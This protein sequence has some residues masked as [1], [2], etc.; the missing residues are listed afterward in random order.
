MHK[1]KNTESFKPGWRRVKFGDVVRQSKDKADPETSGLERYIAGDHMD[2]DDLRLR[3]W[4]EIGSGYLGPAFHMRFKPGQVLYGSRRTYLRKVAIADF[5]G[6]CA[7]TTFVLEPKNPADLLPAFLPF[8]MQT[9]AFNSFSVKNSKGSVNPYINFSD[10]AKFEFLLPPAKEQR[11]ITDTLLNL[12]S[13]EDHYEIANRCALDLLGSYANTI[14]S[15]R[16]FELVPFEKVLLKQPQ[17]GLYKGQDFLGRGTKF[18]NMKELFGFDAITDSVDMSR[19]ELSKDEVE[20]YSLTSNDLLFGRRSIVLTGAGKCSWVGSTQEPVIFE[21]SILRVTV[22]SDVVLPKFI[23]EW[24]RS[25]LGSQQITRIRSFT[26][27]AGIAG[28]D[29]KKISVP[30][31]PIA[32]QIAIADELS[33]MRSTVAEISKR[34]VSNRGLK[35]LAFEGVLGDC[36]VY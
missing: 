30:V 14:F 1:T 20:K 27:V 9:Q 11:S 10:L 34:Q 26:T 5:N 13:L 35:K 16:N 36:N 29:L 4:G 25:P 3:R 2:T 33:S 31:M 23:F 6:I 12:S 15:T 19:M 28:S 21:S 8:L 17:S 22:N 24:L 7:N 18:V 32:E